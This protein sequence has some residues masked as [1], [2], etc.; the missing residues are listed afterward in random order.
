MTLANFAKK[1]HY[2]D[3][4]VCWI[5]P[6]PL[7]RIAAEAM[8]DETHESLDNDGNDTNVYTLGKIGKHNV[9]IA[10][11]ETGNSVPTAIAAQH[12]RY[13]FKNMRVLLLVGIGGGVPNKSEDIRLGD[14]VVSY[15]DG[16]YGG[17]IQIDAGKNVPRSL[18]Q[19]GFEYKGSLNQP[20]EQ[21]LKV[22]RIL[23]G[24][25]QDLLEAAK[26]PE[27]VNILLEA[28]RERPHAKYPGVTEDQSFKFTYDHIAGKS[29]CEGCDTRQLVYREARLDTKPRVHLGL[30]ASSNAVR[31]DGHTRERLSKIFNILCFEMEAAGVMNSFPCLVIR[32]I[33]DYA[34]SHKNDKWQQYAALAAAAYAKEWLMTFPEIRNSTSDQLEPGPGDTTDEECLALSK[35]AKWRVT[36]TDEKGVERCDNVFDRL[37]KHNPERALAY[38]A[39]DKCEN[40][41]SWIRPSEVVHFLKTRKNPAIPVIHFFFDPRDYRGTSALFVLESLTKQLVAFLDRKYG[42]PDGVRKA[43][44]EMYSPRNDNL[45]TSEQAA[46]LSGQR[47]KY[48]QE[49]HPSISEITDRVIL[50]L[51]AVAPGLALVIDGVDRCPAT[52][53]ERYGLLKT[54]R[55]VTESG[56]RVFISGRREAALTE[57]IPSATELEISKT[58]Q[59]VRD[60]ISTYIRTEIKSRMEYQRITNELSTE[61][62]IHTIL[63]QK[64]DA[65]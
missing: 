14:I 44:K 42:I 35:L 9:A 33:S 46:I 60:S 45:Y 5:C 30:I 55:R 43:I 40:T 39:R 24:R 18:N 13:T 27:Y 59:E 3:Y 1:L 36:F 49:V 17:V 15:P 26:T 41:T 61:E 56:A 21:A 57:L 10:G 48:H 63:L 8:L 53:Q 54:L 31:K 32:G 16:T 20:P 50:P 65:M 2:A 29:T 25:H 28:I 47:V 51:V 37:S 23:Q 12:M 4:Q 11:L 38:A 34:D 58:Q 62:T 7:E 22:V 64:A 6:L 19:D 52:P